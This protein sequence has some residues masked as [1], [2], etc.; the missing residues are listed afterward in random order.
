MK[1]NLL[2]S[3]LILTLSFLSAKTVAENSDYHV[4]HLGIAERLSNPHITSALVDNNGRLWV[5]TKFGLN[6]YDGTRFI[7]YDSLS[8]TG[9]KI[10][11]IIEDN[12]GRIYVGTD[13][14]LCVYEP[15]DDTFNK[16]WDEWVSCILQTEQDLL[17]A[18]SNKIV[19][20]NNT[21]MIE[22]ESD[23]LGIVISIHNIN[24]QIYIVSKNGLFTFDRNSIR[25]IPVKELD[26]IILSSEAVDD[27]IYLGVY[28]RGILVVD[29]EGNV[30]KKY[31]RITDGIN[32]G[33]VCSMQ[34]D[35]KR[36]RIWIGTDGDGLC[37][38]DSLGIRLFD[39]GTTANLPNTVTDIYRD[40][41]QNIYA[42]S[43]IN[44]IYCIRPETVSFY[45]EHELPCRI[46]TSICHDGTDVWVGTDGDGVVCYRPSDSTFRKFPSTHLRKISSLCEFDRQHLIVSIYCEGVFLLDK[47]TGTLSR[48]DIWDEDTFRK[49]IESGSIITI[50][51]TPD[52]RFLVFAR[53]TYI[54]DPETRHCRQFTSESSIS[55]THLCFWKDSDAYARGGTGLYRLNLKDLKIYQ[56]NGIENTPVYSAALYNDELYYASNKGLFK[57]KLDC[58]HSHRVGTHLLKHVTNLTTDEAGYLWIASDGTIFRYDGR[59]FI[60][61]DESD[62][63]IRSEILCGIG[64]KENVYL[65]GSMGLAEIRADKPHIEIQE[66]SMHLDKVT[67]NGKTLHQ[68]EGKYH[69][70]GKSGALNVTYIISGS[71][72]LKRR[73]LKFDIVRNDKPYEYCGKELNIDSLQKGT[74]GMNGFFLGND[75]LWHKSEDTL[76]LI[77][78][79]PVYASWWFWGL[80]LLLITGLVILFLR[81]KKEAAQPIL[82]R[83]NIPI[84]DNTI[85]DSDEKM[86]LRFDEL[87]EQN[88]G[89]EH[90][91]VGMIV[92]EMAMSRTALY[93]KIKSLTGLGINEYILKVKMDKAC[94]YLSETN[95]TISEISDHLGFSS[96]RYF[97]T[98][99]KRSVGISPSEFRKNRKF[100]KQDLLSQTHNK[101]VT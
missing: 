93:D 33:V 86:L 35:L 78:H 56:V 15:S 67:I 98:A 53:K 31:D 101:K 70:W 97:S 92:S 85:E 48:Y 18:S 4:R 13:E 34:N 39:L 90:L 24:N 72:P 1:K 77:L 32:I 49:E 20:R 41:F 68:H 11:A 66:M 95:M 69:Y 64:T 74:Y 21:G 58:E 23:D 73:F 30:R 37:I 63:L 81:K 51:P 8:I 89:N 94:Q 25:K 16:V 45:S 87:L 61:Y 60:A 88:L 82:L 14:C 47:K 28:Q 50:S 2:I 52:G 59:S 3:F 57:R 40:P 71:D 46:V 96:Q 38:L 27:H 10:N 44:G 54:L 42:G 36:K 7:T 79:T 22:Y 75:G 100:A 9:N 99:F 19:V 5:G 62:G 55:P 26:G 6:R 43:S 84:L 76:N 91:N 80:L 83:P 12:R 29:T 65:G 17:F